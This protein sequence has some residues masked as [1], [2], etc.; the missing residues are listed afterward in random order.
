M[1]DER[2]IIDHNID[3]RE[4]NEDII[5]DRNDNGDY[6]EE[7]SAEVAAPF[8]APRA[9]EREEGDA[10]TAGRGLGWTGIALSVI[11]LFVLPILL[12]AAGIVV[13]F[14]ARRRGAERLGATAIGIGAASIILKL[15]LLPFFY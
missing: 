2:N 3:V 6:L 5:E 9:K 10:E 11:S 12:G 8:T 15:F 7:A 1:A 14:I 13:G 4:S